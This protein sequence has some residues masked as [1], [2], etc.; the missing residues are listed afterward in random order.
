MSNEE[1]DAL[2]I[3]RRLPLVTGDVKKS[4]EAA[5]EFVLMQNGADNVLVSYSVD[6]GVPEVTLTFKLP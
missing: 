5:L 2:T 3:E 6:M 4:V 1:I